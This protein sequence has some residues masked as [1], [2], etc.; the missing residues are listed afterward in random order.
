MNNPPQSGAPPGSAWRPRQLELLAGIEAIFFA[1]GYR[2]VTMDDLAAELHCSKRALYEI[3]S[4]RRALFLLIVGRWSERIRILGQAGAEQE[5]DPKA[6][7]EAFLAP[8]VTQTVGLTENFLTDIQSL[9]AARALLDKH[10]RERMDMLRT[11]V[12]DGIREGRFA[13][14]HAHLVAGVCLAGITRINDPIFL[15]EAGLT[16]HTAFAELYRLLMWGLQ[17]IQSDDA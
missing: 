17:A 5:Q 4:S 15:R 12:E 10:Q 6:R 9:P 16:F 7:L 2:A 8:G 11:I 1:R 3:A 13:A 14:L